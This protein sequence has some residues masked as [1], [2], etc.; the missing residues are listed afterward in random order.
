MSFYSSVVGNAGIKRAGAR[1]LSPEDVAREQRLAAGDPYGAAAERKLRVKSDQDELKDGARDE[2]RHFVG[3]KMVEA[4]TKHVRGARGRGARRPTVEQDGGG[5][6]DDDDASAVGGAGIWVDP[7]DAE[8]TAATLRMEQRWKGGFPR[9]K[10]D[11]NIPEAAS[12]EDLMKISNAE[13]LLERHEVQKRHARA[14]AKNKRGVPRQLS[15]KESQIREEEDLMK[16]VFGLDL[17]VRNGSLTKLESFEHK[18]LSKRLSSVSELNEMSRLRADKLDLEGKETNIHAPSFTIPNDP[19]HSRAR[20][21][22][23]SRER[24]RRG[25]RGAGAQQ[26]KRKVKTPQLEP[27]PSLPPTAP[28]FYLAPNRAMTRPRTRDFAMQGRRTR[29]Y[30]LYA[31]KD[32]CTVSLRDAQAYATRR[33]FSRGRSQSPLGGDRSLSP[34]RAEA[35]Q[36]PRGSSSSTHKSSL[37]DV[38]DDPDADRRGPFYV[39]GSEKLLI[40]RIREALSAEGQ[41]QN[42]F[43]ENVEAWIANV[44]K[45][46]GAL[47]EPPI[48]SAA[49]MSLLRKLLAEHEA[50][51]QAGLLSSDSEEEEGPRHEGRRRKAEKQYKGGRF[52]ADLMLKDSMKKLD[53]EDTASTAEEQLAKHV[54]EVEVEMT[55]LVDEVGGC[56]KA[57]K[58]ASSGLAPKP[59]VL[60]NDMLGTFYQD[61]AVQKPTADAF[62]AMLEEAVTGQVKLTKDVVK[63]PEETNESKMNNAWVM[64]RK[65]VGLPAKPMPKKGPGAVVTA[66]G[67]GG[68]KVAETAKAA[69]EQKGS[70]IEN[71]EVGDSYL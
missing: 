61:F 39:W 17:D 57:P 40:Q 5:A 70:M 29:N 34:S 51:K 3:G 6:A 1:S 2:A 55:D 26:A 13:A 23:L 28:G 22:A 38:V 68:G 71:L 54:A 49:S 11:L 30:E 62:G 12:A 14:T 69:G 18:L 41:L 35:P 19:E 48:Q 53:E 7:P 37:G 42:E 59:G 33:E 4:Y 43:H 10:P 31:T 8:A 56:G 60:F 25:S 20:A 9:G 15:R 16:R 50:R 65:K 45:V 67:G 21:D 24:K 63:K 66:G 27:L 44:R 64:M 52:E 58:G 47:D 46:L 32:D 36:S